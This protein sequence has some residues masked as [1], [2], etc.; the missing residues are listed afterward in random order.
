[1]RGKILA[2]VGGA[3]S[4]IALVL[5]AIAGAT[6]DSTLTDA[7]SQITTYFTSNVA[8]VVGGFIAVAAA[9]WLLAMLFNSVGVHK[10]RS[11]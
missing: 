8:I 9:L 4:L 2:V 5:P 11:I 10:K 3:G 1:M 6:T 7:K